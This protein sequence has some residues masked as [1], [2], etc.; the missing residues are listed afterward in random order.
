MC[1]P[2]GM[3]CGTYLAKLGPTCQEVGAV[4]SSDLPWTTKRAGRSLGGGHG[5][6]KRELASYAGQLAASRADRLRVVELVVVDDWEEANH[7]RT[8]TSAPIACKCDSLT[9][10]R[11]QHQPYTCGHQST[12]SMPQTSHSATFRHSRRYEQQTNSK[13]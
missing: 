11:S 10:A 4:V 7:R 2:S 12:Q 8:E 9:G 6:K 1:E 3:A 5:R 13:T